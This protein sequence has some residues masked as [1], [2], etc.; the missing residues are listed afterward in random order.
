MQSHSLAA[1]G[2][3]KR[4]NKC[5]ISNWAQTKSGGEI[6]KLAGNAMRQWSNADMKIFAGI[7]HA[8]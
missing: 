1:W 2:G 5:G 3:L 8:D 7:T 6:Q 4:G